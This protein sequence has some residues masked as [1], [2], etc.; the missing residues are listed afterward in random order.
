MSSL[1][2]HKSDKTQNLSLQ[3]MIT[4][5]QPVFRFDS[6][7]DLVHLLLDLLFRFAPAILNE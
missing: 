4:K 3:D 5:F 6:G 1:N 7:S 2:K